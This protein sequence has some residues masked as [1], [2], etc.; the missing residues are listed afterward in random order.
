MMKNIII[1]ISATVLLIVGQV[2][3][4][5]VTNVSLRYQDGHTLARIEVDGSVRFTHQTVEAKDGKP[6]RV[7]VDILAATHHLPAKNFLTLPDCPIQHIRTSQFAVKPEKVVRVVFDM[8]DQTFYRVESDN[9][10]ITV[11]F[12]DKQN[13]KFASWSASASITAPEIDQPSPA[14]QAPAVAVKPSQPEKTVSEINQAIDKDRQLSLLAEPSPPP[15]A[16][17]APKDESKKS[18]TA[19]KPLMETPKTTVIADKKQPPTVEKVA[20]ATQKVKSPPSTTSQKKANQKEQPGPSKPTAEKKSEDNKTKAPKPTTTVEKTVST[21]AAPKKEPITNKQTKKVKAKT[22]QKATK[23]EEDADKADKKDSTDQLKDQKTKTKKR[24][25]ARF[26]RRPTSQSK[27]KGTLVAEFPK[28]LVIKYK[29]QGYR[30]PFETLI[31]ESKKYNNPIEGRTPNVEGIK[32][33]GVLES[34]SGVNRALFEDKDGYGYILRE[35][36]QV[37][38]GYVLRIEH[39]LV[40]FQIFEYGWSRTVALNMD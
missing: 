40:Y 30:D 10:S 39:D 9:E 27:I 3:A 14:P 24:S 34:E 7:I 13:R 11:F 37:Q 36:D 12:P 21:Q 5:Q 8:E 19:T 15:K 16:L 28:R 29:A 38:N 32:L 20:P 23:P 35:G 25:T 31:N 22:P 1:V 26:R 2:W 18:P 6:F 4:S 33:V 17:T